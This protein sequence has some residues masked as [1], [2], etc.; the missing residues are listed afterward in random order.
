MRDARA[1][2]RGAHGFT[3]V[4]LCLC[5]VVVALLAGLAGGAWNLGRRTAMAATANELAA[6]LAL[7]RS[8]SITR[9]TRVVLCASRDRRS[10]LRP[11]GDHPPWQHGW[12]VYAD[13]D[14]DGEPGANEILRGHPGTRGFTIRSSR[15]RR[16]VAYQPL[17]TAGGSTITFAVCAEER[18]EW[19]RYVTVSNTGRARVSRTTRSTMRCD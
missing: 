17:G 10:C 19:A 5:L 12:L 9:R 3:L 11:D 2:G 4:E 16:Q 13:I 6:H 8:E 15:Y 18:P 14:G 7:A 1:A